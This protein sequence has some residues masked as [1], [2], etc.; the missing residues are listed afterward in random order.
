MQIFEYNNIEMKT[1]VEILEQET[2]L[3]K[4]PEYLRVEEVT[5][6]LTEAGFSVSRKPY[7]ASENTA[8]FSLIERKG[9]TVLPIT[10]VNDFP[11]IL[12]R[13]PA[14]DEL[15]QFL[16]VPDGILEPK[17]CGCCCIEGCGDCGN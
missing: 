1:V 4:S 6:K 9:T 5:A 14:N 8:V 16:N 2:I 3:F 12:G 10:L 7:T 13:Y 15:K 11:M 17:K